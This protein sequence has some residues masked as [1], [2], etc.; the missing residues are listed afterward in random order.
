[1]NPKVPLL[2]VLAVV[3]LALAGCLAGGPVEPGGPVAT[4]DSASIDLALGAATVRI[5]DP[6]ARNSEF[7]AAQDPLDRDHVAV[8]ILDSDDEAGGRTCSVFLSE[9]AGQ[10][11]TEATPDGFHNLRVTYDPWLTYTPDGALHVV[12]IENSAPGGPFVYARSQDGGHTW[13]KVGSI[14]GGGDK[15]IIGSDAFGTLHTCSSAGDLLP[16]YV[17]TDGGDEWLEESPPDVR[18]MCSAYLAAPD[19]TLYLATVPEDTFPT[20]VQQRIS[21]LKPG[22]NWSQPVEAT[23]MRTHWGGPE[24]DPL[25]EVND[26]PYVVCALAHGMSKPEAPTMMHAQYAINPTTGTLVVAHQDYQ[27]SG[28]YR[29]VLRGSTDGAHSFHDLTLPVGAQD[30]DQCHVSRPVVTYNPAGL[31]GLMWKTGDGLNGYAVRF[32]VSADDGATWSEEVLLAQTDLASGPYAPGG[33]PP[34]P[35]RLAAAAVAMAV[36][37]PS[38]E[39]LQAFTLQTLFLSATDSINGD[40]AH[41]WSMAATEDL[42]LPMWVAAGEDGKPQV[43]ARQVLLE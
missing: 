38:P 42:F 10:T 30:C 27:D 24:C 7:W 32:A 16:N 21:T 33:L 26:Y 11:W 1:M 40:G 20:V 23:V 8:A 41:Y 4:I 6:G 37:D 2:T 17:S 15:S 35:Q 18:G 12:C 34:N 36:E 3:G 25:R 19:G 5:S 29:V 28:L 9:D 43:Y 14:P 22:G 31:L 13:D 39:N